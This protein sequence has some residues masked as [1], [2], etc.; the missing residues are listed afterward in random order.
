M[1]SPAAAVQAAS[2]EHQVRE[3]MRENDEVVHCSKSYLRGTS[4]VVRSERQVSQVPLARLAVVQRPN[5]Y[6]TSFLLESP[7]DL[8]D[9]RTEVVFC[10]SSGDSL[11][12]SPPL[13]AD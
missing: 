13:Y 2:E 12:S 8:T 4:Q 5:P 10:V 9:I 7:K 1:V 3:E 11:I 6:L